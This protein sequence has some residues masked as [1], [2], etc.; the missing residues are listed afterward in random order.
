MS[1]EYGLSQKGID[2]IDR[3]IKSSPQY[4]ELITEFLEDMIFDG[5]CYK[6]SIK[7]H[8]KWEGKLNI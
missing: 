2:A 8:E 3:I 7:K 1:D 6:M 5:E 4:K